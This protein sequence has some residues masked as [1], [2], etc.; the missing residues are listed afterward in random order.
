MDH[1][2]MGESR[3]FRNLIQKNRLMYIPKNNEQNY[4]N[5]RFKLLVKMLGHF[6]F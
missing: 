1:C 3:N 2:E 4:P 5:S 6:G